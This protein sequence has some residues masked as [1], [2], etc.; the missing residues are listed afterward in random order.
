MYAHT[1]IH[2]K[3]RISKRKIYT[4]VHKYLASFISRTIYKTLDLKL[5]NIIPIAAHAL[6]LLEKLKLARTFIQF[7]NKNASVK[8]FDTYGQLCEQ[9]T[10]SIVARLLP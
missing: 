10:K 9:I 6:A 3:Y 7:T 2:K 8:R 1:I 4:I 5:S